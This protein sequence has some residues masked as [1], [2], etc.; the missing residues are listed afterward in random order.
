MNKH[1]N[2][3]SAPEKLMLISETAVREDV[4]T[5]HIQHPD[6][7]VYLDAATKTVWNPP[8]L[9]PRLQAVFNVRTGIIDLATRY[10]EIVEDAEVVSFYLMLKSGIFVTYEV[11]R[12]DVEAPW[13]FD[14]SSPSTPQSA[15]GWANDE[16]VFS[17]QWNWRG[18]FQ[19]DGFEKGPW[20][21]QLRRA[22][23]R[24]DLHLI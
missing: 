16:L 5:M 10:G 1:S 2:G 12:E 17:M 3:S 21:R 4:E 9:P 18:V 24:P 7:A 14:L 23:A 15:E 19:V 8:H 13:V 22:R 11:P 6:A 20:I